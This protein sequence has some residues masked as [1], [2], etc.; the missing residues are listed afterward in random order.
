MFSGDDRIDS[1][2]TSH[3][4]SN[5]KKAGMSEIGQQVLWFGRGAALEYQLI[6]NAVISAFY[7][8]YAGEKIHPCARW[9]PVMRCVCNLGFVC[10][11]RPYG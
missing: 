5:K 3:V 7:E 11:Q 2:S 10:I 9:C 6:T 1:P 4:V 8:Q